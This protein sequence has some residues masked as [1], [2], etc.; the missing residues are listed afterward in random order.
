MDLPPIDTDPP[1]KSLPAMRVMK[2]LKSVG[3][4]DARGTNVERVGTVIGKKQMICR[5]DRIVPMDQRV[6]EVIT[7]VM[8]EATSTTLQVYTRANTDP[9]MTMT[10]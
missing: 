6:R 8:L 4:A 10:R 7:E 1:A 3:D 2:T 5:I 9:G